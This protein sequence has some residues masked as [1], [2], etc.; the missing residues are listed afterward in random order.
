[1]IHTRIHSELFSLFF[2]FP[3]RQKKYFFLV[4]I[5]IV[6]FFFRINLLMHKLIMN[7]CKKPRSNLH[8]RKRSFTEE[9]TL[10]Y[11]LYIWL[12]YTMSV[13]LRFYPCTV[14]VIYD[15]NT[16]SCNTAKYGRIRAYQACIQP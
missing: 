11:C 16:G 5:N 1:M 2:N 10:V 9:K 7:G 6:S 15:R 13:S 14:T 12:L 3:I 4:N 8:G